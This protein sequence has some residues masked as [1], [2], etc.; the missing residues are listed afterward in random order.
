MIDISNPHSNNLNCPTCL[1]PFGEEAGYKE[2]YKSDFHRYNLKRKMLKL[3]PA[4]LDQ[5]KGKKL[6]TNVQ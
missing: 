1:L 5:F 6:L 2:H 3:A 4:T